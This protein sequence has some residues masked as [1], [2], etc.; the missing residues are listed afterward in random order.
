MTFWE[1]LQGLMRADAWSALGTWATAAIAAVAAWFALRQ[2]EE[3]R[4]T[5]ERV[6]QPEVIVFIDHN[7]KN[8][9]Y[10][11]LVVKNFG[12]TT[13]YNIQLTL[14]PLDVGRRDR[15][16]GNPTSTLY[17]P[18][19]IA[20]LAPGQE[21]RT[22]WDSAVR[23]EERKAE[24]RTNFVGEVTFDSEMLSSST[25]KHYNN[26]I[27]LDTKMFRS[28]LRINETEPAK[29]VAD[30]IAGVADALTSFHDD[31]SGVWVYNLPGGAEQ[32]R[33]RQAYEEWQ[34]D[35]D[36]FMRDAGIVRDSLPADATG[37]DSAETEDPPA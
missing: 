16:T 37:P 9:Q 31:E 20:V 17:V 19:H 14:P 24:L 1:W 4:K 28:I 5:R 29:L 35:Q 15:V 13:A 32:D 2:V 11:D 8:W 30:Q 6:A 18:E 33:R 36:Q 21:W 7:P 27:A 12:Q 10:L 25:Q 34:Q 26:P 3:A 22:V 23:R